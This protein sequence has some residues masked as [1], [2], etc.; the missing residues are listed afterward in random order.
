MARSIRST[1]STRQDEGTK[2]RDVVD[3]PTPFVGLLLAPLL[4]M[5]ITWVV[6]YAIKGWTVF[7]WHVEGSEGYLGLAIVLMTLAGVAVGWATWSFS[8]DRKPV[9][10]RWLTGSSVFIGLWLPML[11]WSGPNRY[12]D[13]FFLLSAWSISAVWA[14]PRLHLMRRDPREGQPEED[15]D[16]LMKQLGLTGFRHKGEP[17]VTYGEDGNPERIVVKVKHRFGATRDPLQNGIRN[18]ESALGAPENL[19]R[20][21]ATG[22]GRSN[23][24]LMTVVL[25]DRLKG[26]V[27]N[28][29]PSHPGGSV[30]DPACVGMYDDGEWVNVWTC[31][32][33]DPETGDKMIPTGYAFMGMTRAGKTVTE[34]R[35]MLEQFITR[36]NGVIL[37][38]NKAKG[39]QDVQPIIAGVEAAVLSDQV[40]EYRAAFKATRAIIEYRQK[41]LARYG[42]S[43]WDAD[44]CFDNPPTHTLR[45]EHDPMEPMPALCVHV[46]EADAILADPT[47]GDEAIFLASKGLSTGVVCGW[48]LQR[49]AATSMPTD[50]RFNIGTAFCFGCAD[51]YSAD[52]ALSEQTRRAGAKPE[53]WKNRKPGYFYVENIG[54]PEE[55]FATPAKG[56]SDTD[57]NSLYTN[58]RLLAEEYG[59]QMS[60]LDRGSAIATR[61]WWDKQVAITSQ[62][63]DSMTPGGTSADT[64]PARPDTPAATAQTPQETTVRHTPAP[65]FVHD[66]PPDDR[67]MTVQQEV[68][69]EIADLDRVGGDELGSGAQKILG[70]L[71]TP[72]ED[73]PTGEQLFAEM[74]AADRHAE[75]PPLD[76]ADDI[77]FQ[78][79]K[80]DEPVD[81]VEAQIRFDEALREVAA[82]PAFRNPEDPTGRSAVFRTSQLQRKYPFRVRSWYSQ[83]LRDMVNGDRICPPGLRIERLPDS[84]PGWYLLSRTDDY[85]A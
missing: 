13:L 3:Q 30:T 62:L 17:E 14:M 42:I 35:L 60:R 10:R 19:S 40:N 51:D 22:S 80:P 59:P 75:I 49:W 41:Q 1:R 72:D 26:R 4:A 15:G 29:G 64:T 65:T 77:E 38:L 5:L 25:K 78:S 45:G 43:A 58:M 69:E 37:Y 67:D 12:L 73:D 33:T 79:D 39:S 21:T 11:V 50:L 68:D 66:D 84:E 48:S 83:M 55:R 81:P 57:H 27:P 18:I 20:V 7:G 63:R 6:H 71:I 23:E 32:G 34:N 44:T 36:R 53:N 28:P 85:P 47:S 76:P 31:G 8:Y 24:S 70:D 56:I 2:Q 16:E 82:D 46:G 74:A 61:G 52:F 54:I 9:W